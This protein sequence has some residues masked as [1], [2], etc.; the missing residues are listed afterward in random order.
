MDPA[1]GDMLAAVSY[2]WPSAAQLASL[3]A[4][5]DA[6]IPQSDLLD[7]A[8][9]G[10]YPPGSAF[11]IV[12]TIAALRKDPSL[13]QQHFQC[14]RLPGGRAGTLSGN[15]SFATT[16]KTPS[17]M[18]RSTCGRVSL[19]LQCVLCSIRRIQHRIADAL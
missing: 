11:K 13:A 5:P 7:R 8:R 4:S 19:L 12:T 3:E 17:R 15:A 18:A 9:F 1:T 2:P 14:F 10:L 6:A 16:S